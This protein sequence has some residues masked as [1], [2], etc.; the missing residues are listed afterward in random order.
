M[1]TDAVWEKFKL[2]EFFRLYYKAFYF[3]PR[4]SEYVVTEPE[5]MYTLLHEGCKLSFANI[6]RPR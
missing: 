6:S 5:D 2:K 3:D 4:T 1:R